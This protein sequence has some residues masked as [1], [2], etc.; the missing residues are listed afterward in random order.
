MS[1]ATRS[2]ERALSTSATKGAHYINALGAPFMMWFVAYGKMETIER[3][4]KTGRYA[5]VG[6]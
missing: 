6:E 3:K 5:G 1:K 2:K 4:I